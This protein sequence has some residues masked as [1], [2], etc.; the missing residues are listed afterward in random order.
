VLTVLGLVAIAAVM[1]FSVGIV[2]AM[3]NAA[4]K[5]HTKGNEDRELYVCAVIDGMAKF[6][7]RVV[8]A[9]FIF[10]T[11]PTLV[12]APMAVAQKHRSGMCAPAGYYPDDCYDVYDS[13]M[14]RCAGMPKDAK[15]RCQR[16]AADQFAD[17]KKKVDDGFIGGGGRF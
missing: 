2:G 9:A 6:L 14:Q 11:I 16:A 15:K 17:C 7:V 4:R 10:G 13:M 5:Q 8:A 1:F 3:W 12:D